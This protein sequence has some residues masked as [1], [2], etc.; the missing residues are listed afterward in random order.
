MAR[1]LSN[2]PHFLW[3]YRRDNPGG[4]LE[5][6]EKSYECFPNT[7]SGMGYQ[8]GKPIESMVYCFYKIT[9]KFSMS[10]PEQ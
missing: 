2:R 9:F 1:Y 7:P 4:M 10:L 8:A 6:H 5:E 3:V